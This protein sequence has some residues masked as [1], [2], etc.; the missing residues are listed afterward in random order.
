LRAQRDAVVPAQALVE[1]LRASS[2]VIEQSFT[3]LVAAGLVVRDEHGNAQYAPATPEL[4]ALVAASE[5]LY[6]KSPTAV[7]RRIVE[8]INPG[9]SAFA[10]AFRLK[11]K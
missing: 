9:L 11:D 7:R 10:D 8:S 4:D 5:D 2:L 6:R 1:A 3:N